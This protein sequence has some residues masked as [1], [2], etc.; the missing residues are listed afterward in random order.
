V[1]GESGMRYGCFMPRYLL[2]EA[3]RGMVA[4]DR[5]IG[6]RISW[7]AVDEPCSA[8]LVLLFMQEWIWLPKCLRS[9]RSVW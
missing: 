9:R 5:Q 8:V 2:A 3:F 1:N 6:A 4:D 7:T